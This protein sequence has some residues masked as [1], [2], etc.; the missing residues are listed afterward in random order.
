MTRKRPTLSVILPTY[1]ESTNL[2]ILLGNLK[3]T[4]SEISHE[5]L[6]VDDNSPDRTWEIAEEIAGKDDSIRVIRR[7]TDRGL[8]SAVITGMEV[9]EGEI[10]AV[11]D[12][13]L[14]HDEN[15]LPRMVSTLEE[16]YDLV[17]GSRAEEGGSYGQWSKRRRFISWVAT[18]LARVFL[19]LEIK[20]PMSGFFALKR[21]VFEDSANLIN[22]RG[23]KILLEFIGR[24]RNLKMR[25]LGYHFRNR[26]HGETKLSGSVVRNY[27]VALFDLRFGKYISTTFVMYVIVGATGILVNFAGF[28]LGEF[29]K[30]PKV[31]TGLSDMLDPLW[32]SVPFGYQLAILSNYLLNN[33]LT[34]YELRHRGWDLLKGLLYF[35]IISILGLLVQVSVFQLLETNGFMEGLV[36]PEFTRYPS[37][38]AGI[39]A[40][41]VSNYFLNRNFTWKD[42]RS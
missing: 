40:A 6:V 2:P 4:L 20:D 41:T 17:V 7:I 35:E 25:E 38:A 36:S 37:L 8:S 13:D 16:G 14:Q 28:Q 11:M 15:L 24:A 27:L 1:N 21:E 5:I 18:F 32:L 29:L 12:A 22:P 9:A 31:H 19:P 34:F 30:L 39:A 3:T 10:F 33:Y 42:F 26:Q 23:F